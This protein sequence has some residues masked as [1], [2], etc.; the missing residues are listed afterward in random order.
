MTKTEEIYRGVV[1]VILKD[2]AEKETPFQG[3]LFKKSKLN[4]PRKSSKYKLFRRQN[5]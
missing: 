4:F 5:Q 3:S 2:M 1:T